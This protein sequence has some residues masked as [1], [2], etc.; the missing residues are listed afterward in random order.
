MTNSRRKG[1]TFERQVAGELFT[2]TGIKFKRNLDQYQ[3]AERGDLTPNDPAWPFEIEC[4]AYSSGT[5]CKA[6]WE[7]QAQTAAD[8]AGKFPA[9]IYKFN[10][11]PIRV[12][13][14][15]DALAEAFGTTPLVCGLKADLNMH[16][17]S[18]IA[19]EIMSRR[20]MT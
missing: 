1:A 12:R 2:Y 17:F 19:R 5:D 9:V 16:D 18:L 3:E 15:E 8:K 13:V 11:H 4:K 14:W 20:A 7:T 6:G 10:N